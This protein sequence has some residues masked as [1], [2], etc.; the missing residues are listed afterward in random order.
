MNNIVKTEFDTGDG[1]I[2]EIE[3]GRLARQAHGSCVVKVGN[4]MILA[5]VVSSY[6]AKDG[7][8]FLPLSVDYQEKLQMIGHFGLGFY[9]RLNWIIP[10]GCAPS[11]TETKKYFV[12]A[13]SENKT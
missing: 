8:D 6:D 2:V 12:I 5:T 13:Q 9:S 10:N 4:T 1:R 3:T 7:V 11:K